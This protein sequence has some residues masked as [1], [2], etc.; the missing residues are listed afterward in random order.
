MADPFQQQACRGDGDHGLGE[1]EALLIIAHQAAPT[2]EP[3]DGPLDHPAPGQ[4]LEAKRA[5]DAADDLSDTIWS[6]AR[7]WSSGLASLVSTSAV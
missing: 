5:V 4:H 6:S 3:A 1:I 7:S 2:S